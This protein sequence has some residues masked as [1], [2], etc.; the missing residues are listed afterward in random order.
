MDFWYKFERFSFNQVDFA[1]KQ[2]KAHIPRG[3]L[4]LP[5][6]PKNDVSINSASLLCLARSTKL[7]LK[8]GW[9]GAADSEGRGK[10]RPVYSCEVL[11][12]CR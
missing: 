7:Y 8:I 2:P 12:V 1:I 6:T 4:S 3:N 9:G 11:F 5:K 10:G